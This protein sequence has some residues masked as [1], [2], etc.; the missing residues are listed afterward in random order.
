MFLYL[1]L[2]IVFF[3]HVIYGNTVNST[4]KS[5]RFMVSLYGQSQK[6]S[7]DNIQIVTLR[8]PFTLFKLYAKKAAHNNF[9][10]LL[11]REMKA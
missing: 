8:Y 4:M 10:D 5:E 2:N 9:Q 3:G 11:I 6:M 1:C 7:N